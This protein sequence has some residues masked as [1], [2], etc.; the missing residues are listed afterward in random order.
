VIVRELRWRNGDRFA[1]LFRLA[2]NYYRVQIETA[3]NF[4][5]ARDWMFLFHHHPAFGDAF[6]LSK[7]AGLYTDNARPADIPRLLELIEQYEGRESRDLAA[8]W[9]TS[10]AAAIRVVREGDQVIG[11]L[12]MLGLTNATPREL[13]DGDPATRAAW[14]HLHLRDGETATYYRWHMTH[15]TY[16]RM[17][18]IHSILLVRAVYHDLTVP[19]QAIG[20]MAIADMDHWRAALT[21][22]GAVE[23]DNYAFTVGGHRYGVVVKDWRRV[24]ASTLYFEHMLKLVRGAEPDAPTPEIVALSHDG[25]AAAV[26][27]ALRDLDRQRALSDN[28]LLYSRFVSSQAGN[29]APID[30][31]VATLRAAIRSAAD[32]LATS[33]RT[34]KFHEALVTTYLSGETTQEAAAESI[35]VPFTTYR[36][37]LAQ[38]IDRVVDTLWRQEYG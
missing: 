3:H 6:A 27:A 19:D 21:H 5:A 13:I 29:R 30:T 24:P 2:S 36:Y 16:Q 4:T 35:G 28:A 1:D 26:H 15:D 17:S 22:S 9:F 25:F 8:R 20:L 34:S 10:P 38:A 11:L 33:R 23:V 32:T 7:K 31:R 18:T 12:V 14:P 37:R